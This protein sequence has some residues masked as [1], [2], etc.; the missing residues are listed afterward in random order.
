MMIF[1]DA[2]KGLHHQPVF[3]EFVAIVG[4]PMTLTS[5][6]HREEN[7]TSEGLDEQVSVLA[8]LDL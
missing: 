7:A 6:S 5:S 3:P 4:L 8:N 2:P 1:S